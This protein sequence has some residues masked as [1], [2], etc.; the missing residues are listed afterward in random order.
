M[1][2]RP[3]LLPYLGQQPMIAPDAFVAPG[4]AVIGNV[5]LAAGSSVW[6][7]CVLRGD[8]R[9]IRIG[10]GSNIQDLSVIHTSRGGWDAEIGRDVT[11]GHH[12]VLHG[13]RLEDGCFIGIGAIILDKVVVEPLAMVAAGALLTPGRRVPAGELWGGS[14]ARKMGELTPEQLA[15]MRSTPPHYRHKAAAY[16]QATTPI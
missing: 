9:A 12:V 1:P 10:E 6:F 16:L 14:P 7:G 3:I 2:A 13:C 4:A 15:M 5:A 11:V 8:D